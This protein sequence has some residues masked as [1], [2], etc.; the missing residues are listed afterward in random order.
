M[1]VP[2][3]MVAA[4]Y[5]LLMGVVPGASGAQE[6]K[7][8]A[9]PPPANEDEA[10][11]LSYYAYD[12][13]LPLNAALKPLDVNAKRTRFRLD[14]D[15]IHDQRIS[16]IVAVPKRFAAPYPAIILVHGS[17]GD[18]DTSYIQ[19]A[20]EMLTS[21]GY[22]TLSI[23][24]QYHGDRARPGKSGEIHL[25]DSYTMR[26][27]WVQSVVD[28]RRAVD[29]LMTRPDVEKTKL[30]Y[31]GFSQGAMLGSVLGGVEGRIGC[32]CLAVPGGG[33]VNIVKH[34]DK[35][36][37]LKA[38]W[39]VKLT[40]ETL[41]TIEDIANVTDPI[42]YIGRIAP[43]PLLIIVA[44]HDEII[45]PEASAALIEAAHAREADQV[46]RWESGHVLHPNALFDVRDFFVT[47][48]G[49]RSARG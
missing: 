3:W 25:P 42:H 8:V 49:K 28:L 48:L 17:G 26:D 44:K 19:W 31:L 33:L 36:P 18:K 16:A 23:D 43:R 20:S 7:P 6:A 27:A 35:Y 2:R 32:F 29:Y 41:L 24:T 45:P 10:L 38:R 47:H 15:S 12:A 5:V 40:P 4:L 37:F 9:L 46:K 13:K 39:P 11:R 22:L 14:Y 1:R 34:L 30:G 21:Q